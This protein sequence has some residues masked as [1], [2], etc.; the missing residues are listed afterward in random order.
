MPRPK[1]RHV[2]QASCEGGP[3]GKLDKT[4]IEDSLVKRDFSETD[5]RAFANACNRAAV[6]AYKLEP[7]MSTAGESR[8]W[9]ESLYSAVRNRD[10]NSV[11]ALFADAAAWGDDLAN[12]ETALSSGNRETSESAWDELVHRCD[13]ELQNDRRR[14]TR[15]STSRQLLANELVREWNIHFDCYPPYRE[16]SDTIF[17][18]I[19]K[20]VIH[21]SE[22]LYCHGRNRP[23][24]T[25]EG[26][27]S[28]IKRAR[29]NDRARIVQESQI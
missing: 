29:K 7:S 12:L 3:I 9:F 13:A 27:R 22:A 11:R 1:A 28:L 21:W 26:L 20:S 4:I 6:F 14:S 18:D 16:G 10:R 5:S 17:L 24:V 15:S 2:N 19:L 23:L 8:R 25:H